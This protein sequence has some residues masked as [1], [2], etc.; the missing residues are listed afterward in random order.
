M[1]QSTW[2]SPRSREE[3]PEA[4]KS[5]TQRRMGATNCTHELNGLNSPLEAVLAIEPNPELRA[6]LAT[7]LCETFKDPL[8]W[9]AQE[10]AVFGGRTPIEVIAAGH[11][12]K[13]L[14]WVLTVQYGG[15][16]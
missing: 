13:V 8:A 14:S 4:G 12:D 3:L 7:V 10:A 6:E 9:L 11:G 16:S 15:V 1:S 2:G 5:A